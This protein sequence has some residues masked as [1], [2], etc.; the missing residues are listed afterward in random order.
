M[1]TIKQY[2]IKVGIEEFR[3]EKKDIERI[4]RAMQ[5]DEIVKLDNGLFRGRS[6]T[7]LIEEDIWL[8]EPRQLS[9]EEIKENL[10]IEAKRNCLDCKGV[11]YVQKIEA[12]RTFM[13]QCE[14]QNPN[15]LPN[16]AK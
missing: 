7:A 13:K 6:I 8:D 10:L 15:K 12:G 1:S 16:M 11:G 4:A 9:P 2:R 3:V 14:C 5:T